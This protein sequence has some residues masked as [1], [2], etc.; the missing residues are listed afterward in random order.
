MAGSLAHRSGGDGVRRCRE[1]PAHDGAAFSCSKHNAVPKENRMKMVRDILVSL[2]AL[3]VLTFVASHFLE[4]S[5]TERERAARLAGVRQQIE[6]L[7][8]AYK[9]MIFED[10]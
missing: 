2:A 10:S 5:K 4:Q 7:D 6:A 8:S 9:K 3:A 1:L